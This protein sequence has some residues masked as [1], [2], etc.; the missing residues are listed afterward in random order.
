MF[1][2]VRPVNPCYFLLPSSKSDVGTYFNVGGRIFKI[3]CRMSA[4]VDC[5]HYSPSRQWSLHLE[6]LA[7]ERNSG[8]G[9]YPEYQ[10]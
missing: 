9:S 1:H 3:G 7:I 6:N 4:S 5:E 10:E 2:T 8:V